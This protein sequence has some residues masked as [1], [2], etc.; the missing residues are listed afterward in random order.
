LIG[1][2]VVSSKQHCNRYSTR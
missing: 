1:I 2:Q